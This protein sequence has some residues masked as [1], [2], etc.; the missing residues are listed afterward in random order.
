M[1]ADDRFQ[2]RVEEVQLFER[3]VVFTGGTNGPRP[4]LTSSQQQQE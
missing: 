1:S 3:D 2:V 4:A